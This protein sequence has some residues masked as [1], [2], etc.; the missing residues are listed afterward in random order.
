MTSIAPEDRLTQERRK[1]LAAEKLLAQKSDEL[2]VVNR[3]L[4]E[5]A[6]SLS[7]TV[8]EQREENT[9]LIGQNS[10]AMEDLDRATEK[11][12]RAERRL[13]DSLEAINDGFAV[14]DTQWRL[15]AAN[16]SFMRVFEGIEGLNAGITYEELLMI[17]VDEGLVDIGTADPD[18][19]IDEMI[20]RWEQPVIPEIT[21][22]LFNGA[23]LQVRESRSTDGDVVCTVKNITATI[24]REAELREARDEAQAA[25]R[26]K[27][28]FLAKMSHEIRTPMNGVVGMADLLL[29]GGLEEEQTLYADTIK[30]SAEALLVIINDILDFS[31]LEAERVEFREEDT[32]L[33][34]MFVEVM[35]LAGASLTDRP[36]ALFIDYP[37]NLPTVFSVDPGRF[38]QVLT[39]LIG[40]AIKFTD[41]GHVALRVRVGAQDATGKAK[42]SVTV[43][44]TGPGIPAD[45]IEHVFGDFNQ[46]EDESNRKHEGT[47]LGLAITRS[48]VEHMGGT[49][50]VTSEVGKGSAFTVELSLPQVAEPVTFSLPPAHLIAVVD[51]NEVAGNTR[52]KR[53]QAAGIETAYVT[54]LTEAPTGSI[55][56]WTP[57]L[58]DP[59]QPIPPDLPILRH[60][61]PADMPDD[62]AA[63][64]RISLPNPSGRAVA[65]KALETLAWEAAQMQAAEAQRPETPEV[66]PATDTLRMLAA[67]DNKTNQLVFRKMLKKANIDI[68]MVENGRLALEAFEGG[69]FDMIFTDI[70]MPEMDG[71]EATRKIREVEATRGKARIP[72][73]AMTAHAMDGDEQRIFEAGVD[74]YMTKP[75]KK[76]ALLAQIESICPEG[77]TLCLND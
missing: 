72:I 33:E 42:L 74:H 47:G 39:N 2:F 73:V 57:R 6:D 66:E 40:N 75:L 13:W 23:W 37:L 27:S 38:R 61:S 52:A 70:S 49:I 11:A 64:H 46:V 63:P 8:I 14:F 44:D 28:A 18:D 1:R 69:T 65:F 26:A 55:A 20:A 43:E 30:N 9:S 22:Q 77:K 67:E 31:K 21:L 76:A 25:N 56:V 4:A 7:H 34:A 12:N 36:I 50:T 5:H 51:T 35:R 19:W 41:E 48:L 62:F 60:G 59:E 32:D 71:M 58:G 68:T 24:E 15:V 54:A 3:R 10:Q 17:A 53:M 45:K 16:A 29:D